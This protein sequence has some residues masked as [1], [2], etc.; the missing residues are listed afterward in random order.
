MVLWD[1]N[2]MR[3]KAVIL[4]GAGASN[5]AEGMKN[6]PPPGRDLF[7]KLTVLYPD[8]WGKLPYSLSKRFENNFELGMEEWYNKTNDVAYLIKDMGI[9]FSKFMID[10]PHKNLYC[11][12][13]ARYTEQLK[14]KEILFATINYECLLEY[15][16]YHLKQ[17]FTLWGN[18]EGIKI[19][20][21]H[22][23]CN[24]ITPMTRGKLKVNYNRYSFFDIPLAI[25]PPSDVEEEMNNNGLPPAMSIY[26]RGKDLNIGRKDIK[27]TQK[28]FQD[29]VSNANLVIVVGVKPNPEDHHIWDYLRD[30]KGKLVLVSPD[31]ECNRWR[32]KNKIKDKV[33]WINKKFDPAFDDI[34]D[35]LDDLFKIPEKKIVIK[36]GKKINLNFI[37]CRK[38]NVDILLP[39]KFDMNLLSENKC[40]KCGYIINLEIEGIED[41]EVIYKDKSISQKTAIKC[42]SCGN[43]ILISD[44]L[45]DTMRITKLRDEIICPKC[46]KIILIGVK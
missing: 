41:N 27:Q 11:R 9:F 38:C 20:K 23:S 1:S 13:I 3:T 37:K 28:E 10:N 14:S 24:F 43:L 7:G 32:K 35:L 26:A 6:P 25:I 29:M 33:D 36:G 16:T 12:I 19:M 30:M 4:F 40:S 17:K 8:T 44:K 46:G 31:K 5:G 34:C 2:L 22:G 45:P 39:N 18:D 15:A 42:G 21:L